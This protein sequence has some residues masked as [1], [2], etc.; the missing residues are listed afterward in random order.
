MVCGEG[1]AYLQGD[2]TCYKTPNISR[3]L[4][5]TRIPVKEKRGRDAF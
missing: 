4:G 2:E 1:E 3:D 5:I